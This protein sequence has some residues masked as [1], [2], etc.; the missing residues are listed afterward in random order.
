MKR[1]ERKPAKAKA[2]KAAK[3]DGQKAAV[4]TT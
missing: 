4:A 3:K 1:P 2:G